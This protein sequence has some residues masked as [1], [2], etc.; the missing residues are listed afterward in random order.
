MNRGRRRGGRG[1]LAV[2]TSLGKGEAGFELEK[3]L[4]A[5]DVAVAEEVRLSS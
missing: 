4:Q 5:L 1:T 2:R 3:R